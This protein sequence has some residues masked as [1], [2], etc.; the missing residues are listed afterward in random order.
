[1][2]NSKLTVSLCGNVLP[3]TIS[4]VPQGARISRIW[5]NVRLTFAL[6]ETDQQP[7]RLLPIAKNCNNPYKSNNK[8]YQQKGCTQN[9]EPSQSAN[10]YH[11]I[12][13]RDRARNRQLL[14]VSSV[15]LAPPR[16][17]Y[18]L[19]QRP[20][21]YNFFRVFTNAIVCCLQHIDT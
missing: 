7:A 2:V 5:V 20:N 13:G 21:F 18:G 14:P 17:Y 10:S 6:R 12:S 1:M 3:S 8:L 16:V 9:A 4:V 15:V 19:Q 11:R